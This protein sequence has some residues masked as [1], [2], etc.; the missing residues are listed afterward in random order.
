VTVLIAAYDAEGFLRRAVDSALAQSIPVLEVLIVDDAS[1]DGTVSVIQKLSQEDDRVRLLRLPVNG[2]P[3][4]ARNAGLSA[5]RGD[6]VAVLDAD[7]AYLPQRLERML[8]AAVDNGADVVVDNFRYYH[9]AGGRMSPPALPESS[10]TACVT[11]AQFLAKA[12]P[13]TGEADWGVLKP[14]FR[15]AFLEQ[16]GLRYPTFSRHGE[17]FLLMA[18]AFL[19]GARYL[20]L[21]EV[22]YL[23]TD[24]SSTLS[25]TNINYRSMWRHTQALLKDERVAKNTV[26]VQ[27]LRERVHAVRRLAAERD[28][29]QARNNRDYLLIL[30]RLLCDRSFRAMLGRKLQRKIVNTGG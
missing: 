15:R 30:R 26:L 28:F 20:L 19:C 13:F 10:A 7:D 25:R 29:S 17:D 4:A 3:S 1:T 18:N 6:W 12:R 14:V 27:L 23:Y 11:F 24:R 21:R 9:P 8:R 22:G 2:G 16:H 5:A